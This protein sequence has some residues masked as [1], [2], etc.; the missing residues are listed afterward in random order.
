MGPTLATEVILRS[1]LAEDFELVHLDTSDHRELDTLGALDIVNVYLALKFYLLLVWKICRYRPGLVY[2]PV[3]Q[4]TIGYLKDSGFILLAKLF[5]RRVICHLRGGNFRNWLEQA[6]GLTRWYVRRVH[7]LIDGQIVLGECLKSLFAGYVAEERLFVVPNGKNIEL[8]PR[9]ERTGNEIRLLY[10]ANMRRTKGPIDVLHAAPLIAGACPE[11][12]IICYGA[13]SEA[14]VRAEI[15]AY[16]AAN[17]GL[18]IEFRGP[19]HGSAKY[20]EIRAADIFLFPTYYPPEGHPWVVVEAMAAGLPVISTDQGAITESVIDGVNGFIVDKRN[21]EAL[22]ARAIELIRDPEMRERMGRASAQRYRE[23]FTEEQMTAAMG[24][25]WRA[26]M[27][28]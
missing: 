3:A 14:D 21:P 11:A 28:E 26:V 12:R 5:R 15:E 23:C 4:T 17:P 9:P 19:I 6:S 1:R 16:L 2:I 20:A 13:W 24:R 18:P 22:A 10:L 27:A 25:A 8:P 7:G